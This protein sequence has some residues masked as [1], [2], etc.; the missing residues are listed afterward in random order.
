MWLPFEKKTILDQP[1]LDYV[2]A[3]RTWMLK[4]TLHQPHI[5]GAPPGNEG[6]D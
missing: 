6:A 3:E 5:M 2:C 4:V 1:G